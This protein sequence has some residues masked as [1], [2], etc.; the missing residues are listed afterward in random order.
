MKKLNALL[1]QKETDWSKA[2]ALGGSV[3]KML[4]ILGI[5]VEKPAI[6]ETDRKNYAAWKQAR[7]A[8]DFAAADVYRKALSD[9][10]IAL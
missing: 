2:Q 5:V 8:K 7:A 9:K 10:G 3:E 6:T 4:K 1:R